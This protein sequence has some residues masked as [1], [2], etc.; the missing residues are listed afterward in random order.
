MKDQQKDWKWIFTLYDF[1]KVL[2]FVY[3]FLVS[4]DLMG[5]AF[6]ASGRGLTQTLMNATS[7]PFHGLIIGIVVTSIVQSSSLTTSIIVTMVGAG[8]L[9][10]KSAVPMIMGANIGTTVTNTIVSLGYLGRKT[11]FQRAFGASI[12]HDMF[13]IYATIIFFPLELYFGIISKTAMILERSFAHIGGLKFSSPL[14]FI[15]Q[16]LS[17]PIEDFIG[18]HYVLLIVAFICLFFSLIQIVKNMKGIVVEKIESVLNRYLF[19]NAFISLCFGFLFTAII[20]SSSITTSIIVPLAGAGVLTIEQIYPYTLGANV[21]TTVTALLAAL[22][23]GKDAAMIVAISHS[24][25][26]VSGIMILYPLKMLP[27]GTAKFIAA[28]VAQSKKHF[29][30]F[31]TLFILFHIGSI[32]VITFH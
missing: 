26:N 19:R 23:V 8:T 28:F 25:F 9:P 2:F 29:I 5:A 11:E 24:V 6:R 17:K 7:D 4:I 20:Q 27:I 32:V 1:V 3:L 31:L 18:N 22:A 15:I 12:I 14:K 10:L 13:N 21:G 16:P 30:I